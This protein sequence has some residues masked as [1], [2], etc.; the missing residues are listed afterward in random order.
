M[1]ITSKTNCACRAAHAQTGVSMLEV[2]IAVLILS[3]G[4]LGLAGLLSGGMRA[5]QSAYY[6]TV[7]TNQAYDMTDR[8]RSNLAGVTAGGYANV[9]GIPGNPGCDTGPCTPIQLAQYDAFDWN[10]T[11]AATLPQGAGVVCLDSSPDDGTPAAP[12]CDNTGTMYVTKVWWDDDRTGTL[13]RFVTSFQ[14]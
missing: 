7:A 5:N 1:S 14:P 9:T 6:R 4:L 12:N 8:M 3:F 10:T 2:L 11:N 13:K